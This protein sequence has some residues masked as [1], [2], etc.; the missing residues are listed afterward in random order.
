MLANYFS[1][2]YSV[3]IISFG[4]VEEEAYALDSR[5][6]VTSLNLET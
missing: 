2:N 6:Q 3:E 1:N 5:V 4:K